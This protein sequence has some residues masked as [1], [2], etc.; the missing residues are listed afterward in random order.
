MSN[1]TMDPNAINVTG[2]NP[3][4]LLAALHNA[5]WVPGTYVCQRQAKKGDITAEEARAD[6]ELF[7]GSTSP[8]Y[9]KLLGPA[10]H[11]PDYLFGRMIKSF[12]RQEGDTVFLCRTD[13][14]DRDVGEG[15]AQRVVDS[16]RS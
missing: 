13:L 10:P 1:L 4:V 6:V 2:I 8:A 12:L 16:L 5:S 15:A 3:W 7:T 14:Y 9:E 11:F